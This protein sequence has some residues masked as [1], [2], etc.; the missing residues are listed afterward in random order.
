MRTKLLEEKKVR[1]SNGVIKVTIYT[2]KEKS[3]LGLD[4][5][6]VVLII[7]DYQYLEVILTYMLKLLMM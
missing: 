1:K 7:L 3:E 2:I 6:I 4:L 5:K